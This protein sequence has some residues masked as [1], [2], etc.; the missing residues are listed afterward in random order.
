MQIGT[1]L[2]HISRIEKAIARFGDRFLARFLTPEEIAEL[3]QRPESLAGYWAAKE[4]VAKALGC[5]IGSALGF[6]DIRIVKTPGGAPTFV[7]SEAAQARFGVTSSSL[8]I[9]HD[10]GLAVAV[11]ALMF[12]DQPPPTK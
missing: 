3:N 11:V 4:A 5:G 10:G 1:D 7:L 2:V 6:H 9:S 8:S 12:A